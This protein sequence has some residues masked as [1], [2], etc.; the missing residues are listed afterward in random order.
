MSNK[1]RGIRYTGLAVF[2]LA[3]AALT[4]ASLPAQRDE[5]ALRHRADSLATRL[6]AARIANR[7]RIAADSARGIRPDSSG[8]LRVVRVGAMT[9]VADSMYAGAAEHAATLAWRE[10]QRAF[11]ARANDL[12]QRWVIR[13]VIDSSRDSAFAVVGAEMGRETAKGIV[14]DEH[15]QRVSGRAGERALAEVWERYAETE[16]LT[17]TGSMREWL[18][19]PIGSADTQDEMLVSTYRALVLGDSPRVRRCFDRDVAACRDLLGL[20]ASDSTAWRGGLTIAAHATLARTAL[21]AGGAD[22]YARLLAPGDGTPADRLTAA[23]GLSI[24]SLVA[25]WHDDVFASKPQP[26]RTPAST[27]LMALLWGTL[28]C[29]LSLR[30][31][32]WR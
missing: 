11:G 1:R 21:A 18:G 27:A 16:L 10:T 3:I 24:D 14:I 7:A 8:A 32:R 12:R 4:P 28:C 13:A 15:R 9:I 25:R 29:A 19:R 22:A 23:S 26:A 5:P 31:S 6:A 20:S 17:S 30:S 2:A